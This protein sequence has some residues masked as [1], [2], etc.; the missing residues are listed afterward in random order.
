MEGDYLYM[1]RDYIAGHVNTP[2][3]ESFLEREQ[4]SYCKYI[5]IKR[6]HF[7]SN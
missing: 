3:G 6:L 4:I 7:S 1:E 5:I 2:K